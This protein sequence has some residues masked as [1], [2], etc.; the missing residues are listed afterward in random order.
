[1]S[2][3]DGVASWADK[4]RKAVAEQAQS[5]ME[6]TTS[7]SLDDMEMG[8]AADVL[9]SW[10]KGAV[11]AAGGVTQGFKARLEKAATTDWQ[12]GLTDTLGKVTDVTSKAGAGLS[13]HAKKAAQAAGSATAGLKSAGSSL[14][15]SITGLGAL[16]T[17]PVKFMQAGGIFMLG[18]FLLS[19][20]MSFLPLLPINPAKF[21]LLFAMGSVTMLGSVAWLRGPQAFAQ[22]AMQRE[23]LPFS[24]AYGVGLIGTFWATLIARSYIFTAFFAFLQ[25]VG[26]L[27]FLASFVPGG[28]SVLNFFGRMGGSLGGRVTKMVL[29]M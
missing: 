1:M 25:A 21:A 7:K 15:S 22:I 17:S 20:S 24:V 2:W 19:L 28:R 11:S 29:P 5:A 9:S 18:M 14:G 10:T 12:G 13:E 26:L 4:A 16:A 27:Y 23:K 3:A 6:L 8:G